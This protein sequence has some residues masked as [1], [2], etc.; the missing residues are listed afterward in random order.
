MDFDKVKSFFYVEEIFKEFNESEN[1]PSSGNLSS[2]YES[3]FQGPQKIISRVQI[4]F[5]KVSKNVSTTGK[6]FQMI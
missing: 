6:I 5:S 2:E 1:F 3:L 4:N